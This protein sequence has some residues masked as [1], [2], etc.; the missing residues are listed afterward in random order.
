MS[1]SS[2]N[3]VAIGRASMSSLG[4]RGI[5]VPIVSNN[6]NSPLSSSAPLCPFLAPPQEQTF[7]HPCNF[8]TSFQNLSVTEINE[9]RNTTQHI[10]THRVSLIPRARPAPL[11]RH[12]LSVTNTSRL[13]LHPATEILKAGN[14]ARMAFFI[15]FVTIGMGLVASHRIGRGKEH[16]IALSYGLSLDFI[17]ISANGSEES[18]NALDFITR[19]D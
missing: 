18:S 6:V 2:P 11:S 16:Q 8:G 17:W 13:S 5:G 7:W 14:S 19:M 15:S 12:S 3:G 1:G 4:N 9:T 10:F